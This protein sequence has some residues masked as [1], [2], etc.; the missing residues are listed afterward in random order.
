MLNMVRVAKFD[1]KIGSRR[2]TRIRKL[3]VLTILLVALILF[4]YDM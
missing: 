1:S 4:S 2:T 3:V